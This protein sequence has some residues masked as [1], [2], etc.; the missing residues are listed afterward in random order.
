MKTCVHPSRRVLPAAVLAGLLFLNLV[1]CA[2]SSSLTSDVT[3]FDYQ[4]VNTWPHNTDAFT[5]GLIFL[6]GYLYESTGRH[7]Q[8]SLRKVDLKTGKVLRQHDVDETFFAEG[9]TVWEDRLIQI[10][11]NSGTAFVYDMETFEIIRKFSYTGNGWGLTNDGEHLVMSDGS[12]VLRYFNPENFRE[13]GQVTVTENGR[14]V[15][16][17]NELQMVGDRIFAN[18]LFEEH[19]IIIDPETGRVTGRVDLEGLLSPEDR[20]EANVLNGI[21]Y[22][23]EGDRLFVTGKLWPA[24]FEIR[25]LPPPRRP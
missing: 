1:A 2:G 6:N 24:L 7:G 19:I 18:I 4:V 12:P 25:L 14:P 8:S 21:A 15:R 11:I 20:K 23:S 13:T 3:R 5:Q 17:I 16:N 10:T 22:D 9:L